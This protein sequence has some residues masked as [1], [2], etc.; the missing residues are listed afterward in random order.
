MQAPGW[1]YVQG[2]LML[3]RFPHHPEL[4]AYALTITSIVSL[5]M[6]NGCGDTSCGVCLGHCYKRTN[7]TGRT[8]KMQSYAFFYPKAPQSKMCSRGYTMLQVSE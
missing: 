7:R 6:V 4:L 2:F 3:R 8:F 1:S 5:M